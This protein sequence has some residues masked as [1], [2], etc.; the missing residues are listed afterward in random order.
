MNIFESLKKDQYQ[1]P[2]RTSQPTLSLEL[3]PQPSKKPA[4]DFPALELPKSQIAGPPIQNSLFDMPTK[5]I[6]G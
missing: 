6:F 5:D 1:D 2:I 3:K 4:Q